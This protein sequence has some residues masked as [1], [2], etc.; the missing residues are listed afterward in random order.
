MK[1]DINSYSTNEPNSSR[2]NKNIII[3]G[4]DKNNNIY[5]FLPQ[6]IKLQ[7]YIRSYFKRR[8]HNNDNYENN[9]LVKL[10]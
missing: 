4:Y 6:I 2:K 8:K 1:E 3:E 10:I 5:D 9:M 7:I